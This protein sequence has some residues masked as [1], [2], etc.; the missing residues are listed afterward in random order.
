MFSRRNRLEERIA[1]LGG[2]NDSQGHELHFLKRLKRA[3]ENSSRLAMNLHHKPDVIPP[4]LALS[5]TM[6][7]A[8][9]FMNTPQRLASL[10]T[11]LPAVVNI[12]AEDIYPPKP[13][14][15]LLNPPWERECS[16]IIFER[17]AV[18][19]KTPA[20]KTS[21]TVGRNAP[22]PCGSGIKYKKC[23]LGKQNQ[24]KRRGAQ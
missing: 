21:K 8:G 16:Q 19:W 14:V 5:N 11:T 6:S 7:I 24:T 20:A 9:E 13:L 18:M 4:K 2:T 12:E 15:E 23:C 17:E 10:V 3:D 22:C 1:Q